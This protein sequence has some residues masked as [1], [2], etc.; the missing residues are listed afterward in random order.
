MRP[1]FASQRSAILENGDVLEAGVFLEIENALR[2]SLEDALDLLVFHAAEPGVVVR[3]FDDDLMRADGSHA[4]VNAFRS[5]P[6]VTFDAIE[7]I[8]VRN[9]AHLGRSVGRQR[10]QCGGGRL[11]G[12]GRASGARR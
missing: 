3:R 2:I 9:D 8:E 1:L 4:I 5:A 11:G 10:E 6:S 12:A 7:R